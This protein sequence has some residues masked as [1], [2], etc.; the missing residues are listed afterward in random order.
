MLVVGC[1][2]WVTGHVWLAQN[3]AIEAYLNRLH[4]TQPHKDQVGHQQR[5]REG[6]GEEW[7]GNWLGPD[8]HWTSMMHASRRGDVEAVRGLLARN[9]SLANAVEPHS[10]TP[11]AC[12][13]LCLLLPCLLPPCLLLALTGSASSTRP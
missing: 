6:V 11:L 1:G 2:G 9:V 13:P 5:A 10:V 3:A 8:G 7:G 12:Y 4:L